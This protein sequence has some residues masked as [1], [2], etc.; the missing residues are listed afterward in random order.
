MA[1]LHPRSF[2]YFA[3]S[4][5]ILIF[6]MALNSFAAGSCSG[7]HQPGALRWQGSLSQQ[8]KVILISAPSGGGKTTLMQKLVNEYPLDFQFSVSTTT[9][10]P[11]AGE[12][13]GK[14]Y[15]FSTMEKFQEMVEKNQFVEWAQVH[16]NFYGTSKKTVQDILNS[17]KS[18]VLLVDIQGAENIRQQLPGQTLSLFIVPPSMQIL[19]QRLRA[20]G[21][22]SEQ[23][24]Q[25]R[26][27]NAR[28][29]LKHQSKFDGVIVNDQLEQA[30]Q[31]L[32]KTLHQ[33]SDNYLNSTLSIRKISSPAGLMTVTSSPSVLPSKALATGDFQEIFP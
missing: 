8:V 23:V 13:N 28:E 29:E 30:Y 17:G 9:R 31:D 6:S 27:K 12:I 4:L 1:L 20:R 32:K 2:F 19:E 18:A 33:I 22:D 26:L 15:H 5:G 14:D 21:T 11:R 24:I 25:N 7:L 3:L 10:A 16:N